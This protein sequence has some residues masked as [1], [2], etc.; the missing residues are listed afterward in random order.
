MFRC[1]YDDNLRV[2]TIDTVQRLGFRVGSGQYENFKIRQESDLPART[3]RS[4]CESD[5]LLGARVVVSKITRQ[6]E[7]H[8]ARLVR[9]HLN[10]SAST[11]YVL[12][13]LVCS[14]HWPR[15]RSYRFCAEAT[16]TVWFNNH[17]GEDVNS[18]KK[19]LAKSACYFLKN[20]RLNANSVP[21][22]GLRGMR[23]RRA[24]VRSRRKRP[25]RRGRR[26]ALWTHTTVST[27]LVTITDDFRPY[28]ASRRI[29]ITASDINPQ[30][31]WTTS[32]E[33]VPGK[34]LRRYRG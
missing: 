14:R 23:R 25:C 29:H 22:R 13:H 5:E 34:L 18:S 28:R 27:V 15:R 10:F 31:V 17:A 1:I 20:S 11:T 2:Y 12:M 7:A 30:N 26:R 6:D 3:I 8:N 24:N 19:S 21:V 32:G 16:A 33:N 4:K 9:S